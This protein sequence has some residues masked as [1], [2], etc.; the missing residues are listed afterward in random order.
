MNLVIGANRGIGLALARALA[1]D[2]ASQRVIATHR[3][4]RRSRDLEQLSTQHEDKVDTFPLDVTDSAG[5]ERFGEY[6]SAIDGGFDL[7]VCAAGI[8]HEGELQPEK[9]LEQCRPDHL[10]SLFRVNSIGPLMVAR[11]LLPGI[12]RARSFTFAALSAMVGSIGDNRRGGWYGY[13]ASKAALNQFIRTLANECRLR[14]PNAAIVAMH[15]GTTD[16]EL[17]Q[18]FQRNIDPKKLYS[19]AQTASRILDVL[20]AVDR[21]KSGQFIN[22]DGREIPW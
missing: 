6:V 5:L 21:G 18:P 17:S 8:L 11:A 14:L 12:A 22:W 1:A 15:P 7:A 2:S 10:L 20:S 4:G 13:R 16:T 19:P 3:P 9:S